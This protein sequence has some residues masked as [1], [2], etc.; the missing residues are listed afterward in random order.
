MSHEE[1]LCKLAQALEAKF[2][3]NLSIKALE[4]RLAAMNLP[5][6]F[7]LYIE[8]GVIMRW[9]ACGVPSTTRLQLILEN[10]AGDNSRPL[11]EWDCLTRYKYHMDIPRF[12]AELTIA[13]DEWNFKQKSIS[14]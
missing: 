8:D 12:L 2:N 7:S 11:I 6:S 10:V 14:R 4:L 5:F 9:G 13:V 1:A 3:F